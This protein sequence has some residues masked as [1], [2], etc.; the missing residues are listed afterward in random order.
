MPVHQ[1]IACAYAF[2]EAEV[3]LADISVDALLI[4]NKNI[5]THQLPNRV[6][7]HG[8]DLFD[9]LEGLYD[10]IVTNP[11]YV[12]QVDISTMPPEYQH[13]PLM[14]LASGSLGL[15][16]PIKILREAGRFLAEDGILVLEVGNSGQHLETL[17]PG[18][19][20]NWIEF[21][22]G[23]H[24]VLVISKAELE[25]YAEQLALNPEEEMDDD[26]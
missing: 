16:H 18:V 8:S 3:T 24:G 6:F 19:E 10:I 1:G 7:A 15:D 12:D 22:R 20:F 13:E 26:F 14:A 21:E 9:Q 17:Y 5:L 4:A 23:G 25:Y 2:P 11:P